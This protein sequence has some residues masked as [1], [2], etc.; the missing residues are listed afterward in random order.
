MEL[1]IR[2]LWL[3]LSLSKVLSSQ[4]SSVQFSSTSR[5][6]VLPVLLSFLMLCLSL[7]AVPLYCRHYLWNLP[8]LPHH[9]TTTC[10]HAGSLLFNST[11]TV[12]WKRLQYR[13]PGCRLPILPFH[14]PFFSIIIE[15]R[16]TMKQLTID[17]ST[18]LSPIR[19]RSQPARSLPDAKETK[20]HPRNAGGENAS[21]LFIGTA[22]TILYV[23]S[24][25]RQACRQSDWFFVKRMGGNQAN[26]WP[27]KLQSYTDGGCC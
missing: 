4:F 25:T 20:F 24:A 22:T 19:H 27:G 6:P 18:A 17:P 10:T 23:S 21:L 14:F 7:V 15:N 3:S 8:I 13:S 12:S 16:I 26:D 9:T 5:I 1:V 2:R 11:S